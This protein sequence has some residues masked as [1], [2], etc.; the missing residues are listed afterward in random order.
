MNAF[1]ELGDA[2]YLS[3]ESYRI[4]GQAVRTAVWITAD[5]DK[6]YCW[7]L[8]NSGKVKRIRHNAEVK[9]ATCDA[10]GNITGDWVKAS[11]RVLDS[12]AAV[13]AQARRMRA[14]YGWKFLIFRHLPRLRGTRPVVIE[15]SPA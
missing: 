5:A 3:I 4:S 9:L 14:K 7:T 8:G 10:A 11:A 12:S 2:T 13:N 6:L 1:D 15:F